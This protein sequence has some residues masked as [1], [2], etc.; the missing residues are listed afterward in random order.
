V[1]RVEWDPK[2]DTGDASVDDQHRS[3]VGLFNDLISAEETGD[4]LH[5]LRVLEQLSDYVL[6][7]FSAEETLMLERGYPEESTS[8][9]V[10]EHQELTARTRAFVLE[11]RES[12]HDSVLPLVV[13]LRDWLAQHI[14]RSDRRFVDYLK[15]AA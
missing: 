12:A 5:V 6:V 7:H 14:E 13:F 1:L 8:A 4:E 3:L 11:Y 9:H 15:G 2:M 10:V